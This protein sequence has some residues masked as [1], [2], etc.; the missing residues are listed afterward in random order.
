MPLFSGFVSVQ[1]YTTL[2]L[3]PALG[4]C[5]YIGITHQGPNLS[6]FESDYLFQRLL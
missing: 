4:K 1:L 2:M 3:P 5:L 6:G